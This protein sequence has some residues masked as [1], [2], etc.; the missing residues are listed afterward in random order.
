MKNLTPITFEVNKNEQE[1]PDDNILAILGFTEKEQADR[2]SKEASEKFIKIL[3]SMGE[4]IKDV[5]QL[6]IKITEDF[7]QEELVILAKAWL[8]R[9]F[10][11]RQNPIAKLLAGLGE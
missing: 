4:D 6:I 5:N 1:I 7:S 3:R 10:E 2:V 11:N 8:S 9:E